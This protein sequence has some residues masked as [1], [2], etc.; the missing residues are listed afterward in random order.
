MKALQ[1]EWF[2]RMIYISIK[3]TSSKFLDTTSFKCDNLFIINVVPSFK[4]QTSK[5]QPLVFVL[6]GHIMNTMKD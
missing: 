1:T 6:Y 2:L 4:K 3:L 5:Q